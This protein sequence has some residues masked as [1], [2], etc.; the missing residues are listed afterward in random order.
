LTTPLPLSDALAS[1]GLIYVLHH[2]QRD[3]FRL[4]GA[5]PGRLRGRSLEVALKEVDRATSLIVV[6]HKP[7]A[8]SA[9]LTRFR[10]DDAAFLAP[11]HQAGQSRWYIGEARDAFLAQVAEQQSAAGVVPMDM[12]HPGE[13]GALEEVLRLEAAIRSARPRRHPTQHPAMREPGEY[14]GPGHFV[15]GV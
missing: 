1:T 6:F 4:V 5:A 9:A 13:P 15:R 12:L 10:K 3:T 7:W 2:R 14:V 11:G 8:H